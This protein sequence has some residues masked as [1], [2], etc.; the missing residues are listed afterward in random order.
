MSETIE[1]I[2]TDDP[3][4]R[5]K[6]LVSL[7]EFISSKIGPGQTAK[8]TLAARNTDGEVIGGL[9]YNIVRKWMY[10]EHL[11]V[12]EKHR[13]Q[14]I[15]TSLLKMAEEQALEHACIGIHCSTY[16][17]LA[18]SLYV[19]NGYK[20]FGQIEDFPEGHCHLF[21]SKKL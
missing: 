12:E 11:W 19:K 20:I 5:E 1:F 3:N 15:A 8:S 18:E 6:I 4:I 14:G 16:S 9:N 21:F 10:I 17:L 2:T 13:S 7:R